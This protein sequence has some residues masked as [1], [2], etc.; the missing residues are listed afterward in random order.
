MKL[1][2]QVKLMPASGHDADALAATLRACNRA[3]TW[4]SATAHA[5]GLFRRNELQQAVYHDTKSAFA[6]AAQ[7]AVRTIKKVVDAYTTLKA[8]IKAGNL[9]PEGSKRRTKAQATPVVFRED[10]AQPYDDRILTWNLDVRTVSIW[11]V[12]G[13][14]KGIPFVG[15]PEALKLLASRKG[16]SDLMMRDGMF[17]LAATVD[18]P[19]PEPYEP[20]GFLGVDL[21]IVNIATTSD[22]RI[23]SG[24]RVNRYRRRML[25]LRKKLQNKR[26]KSAKRAL[27]RIRRRESWYAAQRNHIIAKNIVGT[28]ERTSRGIALED[29][30]GIRQRVTARKDQRSRLHSWGFAQL[31]AFVEYK[32]RRAG[33]PVVF[34]DPRNT[35]RRCCECRH[36]HR[37]NRVSQARFACRSC[38]VVLHADINGS[39]NIA[40]RGGAVWQRG[41]VSRPSTV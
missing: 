22:G 24:R 40:H 37:A 26:T 21:G 41:A 5:R 12:A 19:E 25:T 31:G 39:C 33:V 18:L 9:G 1:V 16:E 35:S 14:I 20:D 36:T 6:L 29:L 34:V 32:A 2:A 11:T 10:A 4:V 27:K 15:S 13:R 38:G 28:A 3:A 23:M 8:N 30:G 7:P 17:F